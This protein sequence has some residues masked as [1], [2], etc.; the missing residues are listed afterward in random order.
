MKLRKSQFTLIELLVIMTHLCGNFVRYI[1]KT[2][3]IKR[4]FLS[5]AHGQVKQY[6]FTLIELL[7]V[8]AIIAI[9]AAMLLPALGKVKETSLRVTCSNNLKQCMYSVNLYMNDFKNYIYGGSTSSGFWGHLYK[10][11]YILVKNADAWS[12]AKVKHRYCPALKASGIDVNHRDY[13][14]TSMYTALPHGDADFVSEAQPDSANGY[15]NM[16]KPLKYASKIP[17]FAQATFSP[18]GKGGTYWML[19]RNYNSH[20]TMMHGK[21]AN[22]AFLDGH[23]GTVNHNNFAQTFKLLNKSNKTLY[24]NTSRKTGSIVM[25]IK[26]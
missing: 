18:S 14:Q 11:G 25:S 7:V 24:Y 5:P 21:V 4:N 12:D 3:N 8:I 2:D 13:I 9:L 26:P 22:I 23:V 6:C 16:R 20:I 1:L 17:F 19:V 10:H 15:W